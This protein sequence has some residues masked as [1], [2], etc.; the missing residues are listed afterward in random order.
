MLSIACDALDFFRVKIAQRTTDR[1]SS[2]TSQQQTIHS[3]RLELTRGYNIFKLQ[4]WICS[5]KLC[6]SAQRTCT[7]NA[8]NKRI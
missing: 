6:S 4:M 1:G 5:Y 3:L 8:T 7:Y 2:T